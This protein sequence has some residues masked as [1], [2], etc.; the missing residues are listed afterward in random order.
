MKKS[1]LFITGSALLLSL[2]LVACGNANDNNAKEKEDGK[3]ATTETTTKE[4]AKKVETVAQNDSSSSVVKGLPLPTMDEKT[5][6]SKFDEL[7]KNGKILEL[8]SH[9]ITSK[10]LAR[11]LTD[12]KVNDLSYPVGKYLEGAITT[13]VDGQYVKEYEKVTEEDVKKYK[14]YKS[15]L[16]DSEFTSNPL[17]DAMVYNEA[18]LIK[19]LEKTTKISQNDI[20]AARNTKFKNQDVSD[21]VVKTYILDNKITDSFQKEVHQKAYEAVK[22]KFSNEFKSWDSKIDAFTLEDAKDSSVVMQIGNKKFTA[23]EIKASVYY[24]NFY[25]D[26][27][28]LGAVNA[29]QE[30]SSITDEEIMNNA[31]KEGVTVSTNDYSFDNYKNN[32]LLGK[33]LETILKTVHD[34]E[35]MKEIVKFINKHEK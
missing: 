30:E 15:V 32:Y 17:Y 12:G 29:Y 8:K 7:T 33:L 13:Y 19:E 24:A 4:D 25:Y 10:E 3:V 35:D 26:T 22:P 1:K 5:A 18:G 20:N 28:V 23:G 31:K 9:S 14:E 11:F 16:T 21:E 6:I 34:D 2:S 27:V